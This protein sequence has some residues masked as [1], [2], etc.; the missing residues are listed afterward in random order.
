[1]I[2]K[3]CYHFISVREEMK[4]KGFEITVSR[5]LFILPGLELRFIPGAA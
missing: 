5:A 3:W 2:R 4:E 1:M